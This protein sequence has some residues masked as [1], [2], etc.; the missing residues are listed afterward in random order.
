M[1][2]WIKALDRVLKGEATRPAALRGGTID[3]P[4]GGLTAVLIVLAGVYGACMG[5]FSLLTRWETARHDGLLQIGYS[6]AKVPMLFFL[7]LLVTFPSLYVFNA[8]VGSRLRFVAVMKLIIAAMAVTLAVLASFGT[9]LVFFS[10]CTTS[11]SFIVL[12]NVLLFGVAGLLGMG[13]L[14][15]TLHRLSIAQETEAIEEAARQERAA[16]QRS[17]A[18]A[19]VE[20][21]LTDAETAEPAPMGAAAAPLPFVPSHVPPPIPGAL[22]RLH[23]QASRNVKNVFRVWVLVFG[24]VGAQISWVLRP[25]IGNPNAPVSFF[26]ER[27]GNFFEAILYRFEDLMYGAP[28]SAHP[29]RGRGWGGEAGNSTGGQTPGERGAPPAPAPPA[30]AGRVVPSAPAPTDAPAT[31]PAAGAVR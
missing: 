17:L 4:L 28:A 6:A 21:G 31:A 10:L 23:G 7:T 8:L 9:I 24:L 30:S 11:Y 27:Q 18:S 26:R 12:L 5:T 25:F 3:L 22:D 20:A 15:Q 1:L 14:L 29:H 19:E 16:A 2:Q 13:F